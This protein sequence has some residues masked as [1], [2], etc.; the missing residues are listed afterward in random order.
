MPDPRVHVHLHVRDLAR[1]REFY[2]AFLGAPVKVKPD[3]AKFLPEFG[4]LNL[5]LT[6]GG[7]AGRGTVGHMGL[8]LGSS[9]EVRAQLARVRSAG[10]PVLEEM[11]VECCHANQDKF[12]VTDPDGVRWEVY[13]L[14][15]DVEEEERAGAPPATCGG[16]TACC[17]S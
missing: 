7:E 17:S 6:P 4:P 10:L 9:A 12:W 5:A 2:T 3:Y 15:F 14:N 1:S 11:N 8:Q 16:T 13:H